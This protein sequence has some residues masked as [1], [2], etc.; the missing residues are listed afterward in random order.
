MAELG[1]LGRLREITRYRVGR[2]QGRLHR[3]APQRFMM[4]GAKQPLRMD[5]AKRFKA[6]DAPRE[7]HGAG[8]ERGGAWLATLRGNDPCRHMGCS[9]LRTAQAMF[10]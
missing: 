2:R 10:S 8:I 3:H 7:R 9:L 4:S 6:H 5:L 1:L